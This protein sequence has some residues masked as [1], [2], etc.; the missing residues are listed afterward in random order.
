MEAAR[1]QLTGLETLPLTAALS[2]G[3]R[4]PSMGAGPHARHRGG[5]LPEPLSSPW[6]T[7]VPVET[8]LFILQPPHPPSP[9]LVGSSSAGLSSPT[10][11]PMRNLIQTQFGTCLHIDYVV[12]K[13]LHLRRGRA[14]CISKLPS[15]GLGLATAL[16]SDRTNWNPKRL[17]SSCQ[18]GGSCV[19][20]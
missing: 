20:V 16:V 1:L 2:H 4:L 3:P 17:A 11:S 19:F 10:G 14:T 9:P 5:G 15:H 12:I 8:H 6:G 7:W 13:W 18:Q